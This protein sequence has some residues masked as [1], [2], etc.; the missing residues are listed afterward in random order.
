M[1][2]FIGY[3]LIACSQMLSCDDPSN[4]LIRALGVGTKWFRPRLRTAGG[5]PPFSDNQIFTTRTRVT[6]NT[7]LDG[8]TPTSYRSVFRPSVANR[9]HISRI[10]TARKLKA[11]KRSKWGS[12]AR[13]KPSHCTTKFAP[14]S[15]PP[16][17]CPM[18][19][20]LPLHVAIQCL[21]SCCF[22]DVSSP[23]ALI[24]FYGTCIFPQ[25]NVA[26]RFM[27]V[28]LTDLR[29]GGN[30]R[31]PT[32]PKCDLEKLRSFDKATYVHGRAR[33]SSSS[34]DAVV[35]PTILLTVVWDWFHEPPPPPP[36]T[37][38]FR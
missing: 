36:Q 33:D 16:L 25:D 37:S 11:C 20:P 29:L 7:P 6:L 10:L 24:F 30:A 35:S 22:R 21:S 28:R 8:K 23:C 26:H 3:V 14:N 32:A 15:A 31:R 12:L 4:R 34:T 38:D 1:G 27:R 17:P 19:P 2:L 13:V 5:L 18:Y 9:V